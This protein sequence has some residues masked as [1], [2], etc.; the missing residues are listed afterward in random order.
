MEDPS[1]QSALMTPLVLIVGFLG[2]GKTTFL[3]S[4]LPEIV[5]AGLD[6]H[7]IINDYQNA[8]VDAELLSAH[9]AAV[10]PI[11]GSCVCC[12]SREE[13]VEAL[14][15]LDHQP[16]RV[17]L[18]E[19]NG[20][21]DAEELIEL[22]S[23]EPALRRF[24]LPVQVSLLDGQRWQKRLWH[25]GLELDQARTATYRH[26]SRAAEI[27]PE[28]RA[29]V[30]ESLARHGVT[31]SEVTPAEFARELAGISAAVASLPSRDIVA[32]PHDCGCDDPHHEHHHQDHHHQHEPAAHHFAAM[33][34]DLPPVAAR[35]A[36]DAFL[37]GLP[38]EVLRV[39]GLA[40]LTDSPGEYHV[41]QR[42]EDAPAQWLP[43]GPSSRVETPLA[44]LIGPAVDAEA[45]RAL[46][47]RHLGSAAV[48]S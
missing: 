36:I 15:T 7:V 45:V 26:V 29:R 9:A 25:N 44:I 37:A 24:T 39:K 14:T 4:A 23:L 21:T 18:I 8:R 48:V 46:A 32:H 41:F 47:A 20:T 38:R 10:R 11:S 5:A 42:V 22:L 35:S 1:P 6:P 31:A 43:I 13:L 34:V 2:A 30:E 16:G 28:R 17:V 33:Q 12:G 19:A 27:P 40:R 3:R